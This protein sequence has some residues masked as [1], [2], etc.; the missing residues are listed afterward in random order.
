MKGDKGTRRETDEE[1]KQ[2]MEEERR[3]KECF[4]PPDDLPVRPRGEQT[5]FHGNLNQRDVKIK[6]LRG[7]NS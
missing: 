7:Q 1:G 3:T 5:C 4:G 6:V 2:E